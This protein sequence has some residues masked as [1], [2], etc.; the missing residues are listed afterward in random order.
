MWRSFFFAVGIIFV[1]LGIQCLLVDQFYVNQNGKLSDLFN[2]VLNV[3]DPQ[4][5]DGS[6]I[7]ASSTNPNLAGANFNPSSRTMTLPQYGSQYG[8]SRFQASP[9]SPA[10][11]GYGNPTSYGGQPFQN[12]G[13]A[14]PVANTS[15]GGTSEASRPSAKPP[16]PVQT[17]DWMPWCFIAAGTIISL[18][19]KSL[20]NYSFKESE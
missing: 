8:P 4:K 20:R 1:L 11:N 17:K 18:Y 7:G 15:I 10:Q 6:Q 3:V 2:K 14:Q 19:T 13:F 16:R 9:Y 5:P 12:A